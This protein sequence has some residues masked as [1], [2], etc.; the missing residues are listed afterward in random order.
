[1]GSRWTEEQRQVIDLRD[2][3]MLVSAAAGSGKT[4]VLVERII[5]KILDERKPADID[6]LLVVTFTNAAAGEMRERI[7]A[8]LEKRLEEQPENEHLQRQI[9]LVHHAQITT[10][11][12]FCLEVI[13]NH[14][15]KIGLDPG[16]RIG[17]EG[18]LKLL[19]HDVMEELLEEAYQEKDPE[20]LCFSEAFAPGKSDQGLEEAI[21]QFYDFSMGHPWPEA[22]RSQC[23]EAY[24]ADDRLFANAPWMQELMRILKLRIQDLLMIQKGLLAIVR[25]PDG[26]WM[27]L[28]AM[29]EDLHYLQT[30]EKCSTYEEYYRILEEPPSWQTL[31][32]KKDEAVSAMKVLRVKNL[33]DVIK[34]QI[35]KLRQT[36]FFASP[37]Q[38]AQDMA[39]N[40]PMVQVLVDLTNRFEKAYGQRKAEKNLVD[41]NDLEHFALK[42]L[43]EPG[44][45]GWL[46]TQT[47]REY[48]EYY[49]EIMID[50]Y[51]D[52]NLVQEILLTS[53]S[54]KEQGIRNLFMVGDVKQS[55]YRFRLARPELFME[56]YHTYQKGQGENRRIDLHKNFRSRHQVLDTVNLIFQQLMTGAVGGIV[57]DE[58]A[59]LYPGAQFPP[60]PRE[61]FYDTEVLLIEDAQEE[62]AAE[63]Q[64]A[65]GDLRRR[66]AMAAALRI[67]QMAGK[68][69][70]WDK[71]EE[72][73]RPVRYSDIVILLRTVSGWSDV[74]AQ[75]LGEFG[76]PAYTGGSTGYFSALEVKT[77]LAYLQVLDN[78]R[79]DIPLAA[80]LRSPIGGLKDEELARLR[81]QSPDTDFY[82]CCVR[83]LEGQEQ[84]SLLYKKLKKFWEMTEGFRDML[85]YTPM[86]L[87]LW[88]I[89]D[90][91]GYGEYVLAMPGGAQRKA[92]LDMLA[93]KAMAYEATSYRGLFNFVRYIEHLQK[94]EIDYG[95]ASQAG[96]AEDVVRLMSIHKSKGLE[97]PVVFVC[98]LG[99]NFNLQDSRSRLIFHP[100]LGVGCDYVDLDL[101][102]KLPLLMKRVMARQLLEENLGEELRVLYVAMTR[103][104]EKL[105]LTGGVKDLEK[106]MTD[107]TEETG[108]GE[109]ALSYSAIT[110]A[111]TCLDWV[112]A[113]LLRHDCGKTLL[114]EF[115]LPE[116]SKTELSHQPGGVVF[117]RWSMEGLSQA[118]EK[119][120]EQGMKERAM[121]YQPFS[122]TEETK[123]FGEEL[124]RRISLRYPY[125]KNLSIPGKVTVS[126]LKRMYM[127]REPR[128][129]A[130]HLYQEPEVVP[131]I[132]RF[133]SGEAE[134]SGAARGTIYH[135]F[136]EHLEFGGGFD[137]KFT[138]SQLETMVKCGKIQ[139]DEAEWISVKKITHFLTSSLGER[140]GRAARAG[141]LYR[142]QPFV[143]GVPASSLDPE[144]DPKEEV[145]IQGII[146][147]YFQEGDSLVLVDYKTDQVKDQEE[148]ER[149]YKV[150]L[151]CYQMALECLMGKPVKEKWI[152]SF[153]LNQEVTVHD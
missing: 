134:K 67:R 79:Q 45:E 20:F 50:E 146:D 22:F 18:E 151:L 153:C 53:V 77:V 38:M 6:R 107:W 46:P 117:H 148:L 52:S 83:Y 104:R 9:T 149:R 7:R 82:T 30:L 97:F 32:R 142:E 78:P 109:A 124:R 139:K 94:Y 13:R 130:F 98:G 35:D 57:Y 42:I 3:N 141:K 84:S 73:F 62:D 19:R 75:V 102:V 27:Y 5:S 76:I 145:L 126:L 49:Q 127:D 150:Q 10:I 81:I 74:F 96:E 116:A 51:Q 65:A 47:A 63:D 108:S 31:S 48:A 25:E 121:L 41:F 133:K 70:I 129:E 12:S 37:S 58:D 100:V 92:N 106:K 39:N 95:E 144:W 93:E 69:Q 2:C 131:L 90:T 123:A 132:P 66:E 87:L 72:R 140:M 112:M 85:P 137:R 138:E 29:E 115:D 28:E 44:E 147:A 125:E 26:P 99:K 128:E 86:H 152:Y 36:Y 43:V 68:E 88:H 24:G 54:G 80:V 56:K 55:I 34:K 119:D 120:I 1:M 64:E 14:F 110:S 17:D 33:R 111:A 143:L 60:A 23:L 15:H 113:A 40:R 71:E 21:L 89:L 103:A 4:A 101:R 114:E 11:H 8:A 91:T 135:R 16:F 61:E 118:R 136:L 105:I 122:E 59:A